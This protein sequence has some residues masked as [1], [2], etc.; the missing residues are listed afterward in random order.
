MYEPECNKHALN[1]T[2]FSWKCSETSVLKGCFFSPLFKMPVGNVGW[3]R[4]SCSGSEL[5]TSFSVLV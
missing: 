5:N 4:V 2:E 3:S 1:I